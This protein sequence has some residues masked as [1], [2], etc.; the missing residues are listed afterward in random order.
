MFV[1][2]LWREK[3]LCTGDILAVKRKYH[4]YGSWQQTWLLPLELEWEAHI[5]SIITCRLLIELLVIIFEV[6]DCLGGGASHSIYPFCSQ[7]SIYCDAA[8]GSRRIV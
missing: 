2:L 3:R 8:I 7:S 4:I 5:S 6:Y 1:R